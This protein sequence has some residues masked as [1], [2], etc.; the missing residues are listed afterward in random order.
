M[1]NPSDAERTNTQHARLTDLLPWYV[2]G[3]LD[4]VDRADVESHLKV[5]AICRAELSRCQ[6]LK[7]HLPEIKAWKPSAT[8][9][10][11]ILDQVEELES[12]GPRNLDSFSS[13]PNGIKA[14]L[15]QW[16]GAS[17]RPV[18]WTLGLESAA[19]A[20]LFVISMLPNGVFR[21]SE[22]PF[23][24]LSDAETAKHSGARI[25]LV[26]APELSEA[27]MRALLHK[28]EAQLREGPSVVGA[29]TVEVEPQ[30]L[31]AALGVFR[32]HPK[33]RLAQ[34]V[35]SSP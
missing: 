29:Y 10:S 6:A 17:P 26:F 33:V 21:Q 27:E 25:R 30:K 1:S 13:K 24:T 31:D 19:L 22:T 8:H 35:P 20:A 28:T 12:P 18:C 23:E 2:N 11:K 14:R 15:R 34:A 3:T 9:F 32:A 4:K 16:L 7:E 5:C